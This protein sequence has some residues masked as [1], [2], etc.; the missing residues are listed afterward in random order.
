MAVSSRLGLCLRTDDAASD[1][2]RHTARILADE[3]DSAC[4]LFADDVEEWTIGVELLRLFWHSGSSCFHY[5][6]GCCLCTFLI[7]LDLSY[8]EHITDLTWYIAEK[9]ELCIESECFRHA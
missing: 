8:L 5:C 6:D 1:V 2:S 4:R 3:E 9:G 7:E